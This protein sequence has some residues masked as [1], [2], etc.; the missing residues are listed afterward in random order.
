MRIAAALLAAYGAAA[1]V[2]GYGVR[3]VAAALAA[4]VLVAVH[5]ARERG[6]L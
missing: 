2:A 1:L 6:N 3:G 4:G 5:D